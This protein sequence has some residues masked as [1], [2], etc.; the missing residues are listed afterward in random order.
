[1]ALII[2]ISKEIVRR[3]FM[4]IVIVSSMIIVLWKY[5]LSQ[6]H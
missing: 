3:D 6:T 1:V 4:I 2:A 5:L